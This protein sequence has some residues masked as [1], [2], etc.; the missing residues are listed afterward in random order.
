MRLPATV[1]LP[2][3]HPALADDG[4]LLS[5]LSC[6]T[7]D[8]T[9]HGPSATLP[10][11]GLTALSWLG[12]GGDCGLAGLRLRLAMERA[13]VTLARE[14]RG[15]PEAPGT[16]HSTL[17]R[18]AG[19]AT[20]PATAMSCGMWSR[21]QGRAGATGSAKASPPRAARSSS[22]RCP[23]NGRSCA[24]GTTTLSGHR[25]PPK[26]RG[27]AERLPEQHLGQWRRV[28]GGHKRGAEQ[29]AHLPSPV[30]LLLSGPPPTMRW[31]LINPPRCSRSPLRCASCWPVAGWVLAQGKGARARCEVSP[32]LVSR[33]A[34]AQ[35]WE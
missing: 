7:A 8:P 25:A 5:R 24:A 1:P 2:P 4:T 27:A 10:V 3:P 19:P 6:C 13:P 15:R 33:D 23:R 17:G 14:G 20:T 30:L 31:A 29:A 34:S 32:S 22:S 9:H 18:L 28:P 12:L 16:A 35:G 26:G 11:R 21:G